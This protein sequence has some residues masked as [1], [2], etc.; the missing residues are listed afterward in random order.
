VKKQILILLLKYGLGIGVLAWLIASNWHVERDG[1]DE[2]LAAVL[3]RPFHVPFFLLAGVLCLS[4]ILLTFVR[5]YLLAR[6]QD[7]PFQISTAIRLGFVGNFMNT[8]LP[9]AVGGDLVKAAFVARE[10][11]RRTVA[12]ATV[13]VDRL[14]GLVGL[15]WITALLGGLFWATEQIP[16]IA[17]S[18]TAVTLLESIILGTAILAAASL[19]VWVAMGVLPA[20]WIEAVGAWLGRWPKVGGTLRELWHAVWLYRRRTK[21]VVLCLGMSMLNHTFNFFT[22]YCAARTVC[23]PDEIPSLAAHLLIVPVGATVQAGFPAPGGM[24]GGEFFFGLLYEAMGFSRVNGVLMALV[25]RSLNWVLGFFGYLVSL[26]MRS[27]LAAPTEAVAVVER[28]ELAPRGTE[29]RT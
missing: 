11:S 22:Y 19:V 2:G 16:V 18:A 14:V 20:R 3:D 8:F 6:A 26:W 5:W 17:P 1:H 28:V 10:Q 24:G 13:L 23:P 12:V 21:Y 29:A 25:Q 27:S 9:G 4:G 15:I 7:L